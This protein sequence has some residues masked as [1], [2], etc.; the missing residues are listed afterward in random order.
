MTAF[1]DYVALQPSDANGIN[2][3][4]TTPDGKQSGSYTITPQLV[5]LGNGVYSFYN[6][7]QVSCD[8]P[9]SNNSELGICTAQS[10]VDDGGN[11]QNLIVYGAASNFTTDSQGNTVPKTTSIP[12]QVTMRGPNASGP[13]C[14]GAAPVL[15]RLRGLRLRRQ[16]LQL[17]AV[18]AAV[19]HDLH[20]SRRR[21]G[22]HGLSRRRR[23]P[24]SPS[25]ERVSHPSTPTN[26]AATGTC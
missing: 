9:T 16:H 19:Q 24:G 22:L 20:R 13:P 18:Q 5:N 15:Q 14:A 7:A 21:S 10:Y 8:N 25:P 6:D 23:H 4:Y 26:R 17:A 1:V 12:L 3:T 2:Y 11:L